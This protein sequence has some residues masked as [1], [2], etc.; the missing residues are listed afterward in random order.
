MRRSFLQ[1]SIIGFMATKGVFIGIDRY[2]DPDLTELGGCARDALALWSLFKDTIPDLEDTLLLNADATI[3]GIKNA[4][5]SALTYAEEDDTV[6][7]SYAG[8]G[9]RSHCLTAHNTSSLNYSD[10]TIP[11]EEVAA[12]FNATRA[13]SVLFILD[14]CFSGEAPARVIA[15]SPLPRANGFA[16]KD[17]GG[18]GKIML[19]ACKET[20]VAWEHPK[21]KHGLLTDAFIQVFTRPSKTPLNITEGLAEAMEIVSA[22][23]GRIGHSQ[24]ASLFGNIRGGFTLPTLVKGKNYFVAFPEEQAVKISQ[25]IKELEKLGIPKVVVNTWL[26][27]FPNGLNELQLE[28]VNEKGLLTG[29]NLLVVAPT[30]SGKT[31]VGEMAAIK[32]V[33]TGKK[34]V[35]LIPYKALVN[36]KYDEFVNQYESSLGLRIIRCTGDYQDQLSAFL[37]GKYDLAILTYEMFLN[38]A[39]GN[40]AVLN[41]LGLVVIDEAQ[42]VTNPGR[43]IVVELLLTFLLTARKKEIAP[44][45]VTLSAVIGDINNFDAWLGSKSLITTKRPVPLI[46]GVL[47]RSG[48]YSFIDESGKSGEIQFLP[49]SAII[50]RN[51]K[52]SGQD[53]MVPL[54]QQLLQAGE[55]VLVFRNQK[56]LAEGSAKYLA[57]DLGL[58]PAT[59]AIN[60]LPNH[61]LSASSEAL[62]RCLEGGT[63]FHTANLGRDEKAV[64]EK[65]YRKMDGKVEVLTATTTVAAGINTPASTVIIAEHEFLGDD[66]RP[67]TVSEYKN[68]AGRAGRVGYNEKGRSIILAENSMQRRR[69]MSDYVQKELE[70]LTS[71]FNPEHINTWVLRLLAQIDRMPRADIGTLLSNT[72][73]GYLANKTD[74]DWRTRTEKILN[75][76]LDRMLQIELLEEENGNVQLSLLGRAC[77]LSS[78]SFESSLRLVELLKEIDP[79]TMTAEKLMAFLQVLDE[80]DASYTPII[81]GG[82]AEAVR[83]TEAAN[84][85]GSDTVRLLQRRAASIDVYRARCK[86]AAILWDWTHGVPVDAIEKMYTTTPYR[87]AITYGNIQGFADNTRFH[88]RSASQILSL[89]FITDGPTQESIDLLLKQLEVGMPANGVG[90]LNLPFRLTRGEYLALLQLGVS[91]IEAFWQLPVATLETVF[92]EEQIKTFDKSR[93]E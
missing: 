25:D 1:S 89:I 11:M 14:C 77:G 74:P 47:D 56:G 39:V 24:T 13:K 82:T 18:E 71:S 23:A 5:A 80:A 75:D 20:E 30:S 78:L 44:Q 37:K 15:D 91:T 43:G 36:E 45:V 49:A 19:A 79:A 41:L 60:E 64:V 2:L 88:L 16:F 68:M 40:P 63:A 81:K 83:Q 7:I 35:F 62:R 27:K 22:E 46:E 3:E 17:I 92:T 57:R 51:E 31:F 73:G 52:P 55:R 66:G 61:D 58:P 90:L 26:A 21:T 70:P 28:A 67:F 69:L 72:Y 87:G 76:L 9:T 48:T 59:E 4:L 32:A 34:A 54:I 42:F 85:Y 84:R 6:I 10:T 65:A 12:I 53:V 29:E 50:Q 93:P 86:R 38:L 33:A 8:H